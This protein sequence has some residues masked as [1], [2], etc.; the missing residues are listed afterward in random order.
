MIGW[1]PVS[2]PLL[3]SVS[4]TSSCISLL[5]CGSKQNKTQ[6]F[7]SKKVTEYTLQAVGFLKLTIYALKTYSAYHL[8]KCLLLSRL[9]LSEHMNVH[10]G[11]TPYVCADCGKGFH[12]RAQLKQH[13]L[14]HISDG[15]T[16]NTCS[17]CGVHFARR[18]N[19]QAHMKVHA[20]DRKFSCRLCDQQFPTVGAMLSHRRQ[21]SQDDIGVQLLRGNVSLRHAVHTMSIGSFP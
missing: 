5:S 20:S 18:S 12:K 1:S 9:L 3:L 8:P 2:T 13:T 4:F 6:T 15:N 10:T 7:K 11:L 14:T 19:L 21:H 16:R 17:V